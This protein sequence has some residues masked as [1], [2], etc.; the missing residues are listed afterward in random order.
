MNWG[1]AAE[2]FAM[3]G[4]GYF[5]WMSYAAPLLLM[6]VEPALAYT[7]HQNALRNT[8]LHS[9]NDDEAEA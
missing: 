1:S 4:H 3:G 9:T 6:V 2:F 5:V 7:R 8:R